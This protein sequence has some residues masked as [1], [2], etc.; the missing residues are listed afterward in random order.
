MNKHIAFFD[1]DGTI[2]K[3]DSLFEFI[4]YCFGIVG[5][6]KGIILLSPVLVLYLVKIIPNYRAKEIFL[7][8]FFKGFSKEEFITKCT[9]FSERVLPKLI[10]QEALEKIKWHKEQKH[11]VV[12]VSA[13]INF[14]LEPWCKTND[15][16][17][18][19]S[20]LEFINNKFTGKLSTKNC[21]GIEKENRIKECISLNEYNSIFAYGDTKG[22]QEMLNLA[23]YKHYRLFKK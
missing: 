19:A 6:L 17:L 4:K 5:L 8:Y 16:E 12:V 18:I 23:N 13:S 14:W 10:K 15:I 3:K 21:Y 7:G 9:G 11:R 20:E 22:D 2:T 1:F